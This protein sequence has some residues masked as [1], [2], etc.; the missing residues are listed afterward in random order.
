MH[1]ST[2]TLSFVFIGWQD[3]VFNRL[4]RHQ[5]WQQHSLFFI[6]LFY[7][8]ISVHWL[9]HCNAYCYLRSVL[10]RGSSSS[11]GWGED[12]KT[13]CKCTESLTNPWV[14]AYSHLKNTGKWV[15]GS[16]SYFLLQK[17]WETQ[18]KRSE[19]EENLARISEVFSNKR[20]ETDKQAK[21]NGL[22]CE[23]VK[24]LSGCY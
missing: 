13:A 10:Q 19:R 6:L 4:V 22:M 18:T 21:R 12:E 17:S 15:T 1:S 24:L 14:F 7:S 2:T 3:C 8:D 9:L 5:T 20:L 11:F 23:Q 16:E